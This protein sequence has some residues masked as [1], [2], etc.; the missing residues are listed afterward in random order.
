LAEIAYGNFS[1]QRL[2]CRR[3]KARFLPAAPAECACGARTKRAAPLS[4][5]LW[6]NLPVI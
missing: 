6:F 3:Q 4:G 2:R 5:F 1:G